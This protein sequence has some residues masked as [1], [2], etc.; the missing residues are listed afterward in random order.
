MFGVLGLTLDQARNIGIA[1]AVGFVV[2]AFGAFWLMK[3]LLQKLLVAG[4]LVVLAFAVWTQRTA[5][6][7]CADKVTGNFERV[8][9]NVTVT[10]TDCSFFGIT[11]TISDPRGEDDESGGDASAGQLP[12]S[13]TNAVSRSATSSA[14][15]LGPP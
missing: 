4:V 8:G 3:T 11:V 10:D 13:A 6:Q 14:W 7:D 12:T 5:L 9:S 15:V 1:V 2:L